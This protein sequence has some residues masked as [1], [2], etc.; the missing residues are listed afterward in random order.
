MVAICKGL[1]SVTICFAVDKQQGLGNFYKEIKK[2]LLKSTLEEI[3]SLV[4]LSRAF[5]QNP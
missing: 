4:L 3:I 5:D 2:A 1:W